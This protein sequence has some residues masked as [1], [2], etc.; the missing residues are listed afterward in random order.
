MTPPCALLTI[1]QH[2]DA[3]ALCA[4]PFLLQTR[5]VSEKTCRRALGL[6]ATHA[7]R[8]ARHTH[9]LHIATRGVY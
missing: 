6:G 7:H 5:L 9:T 2:V 4:V 8:I 3:G 1:L